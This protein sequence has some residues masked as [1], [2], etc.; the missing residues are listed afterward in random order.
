[1]LALPF[2]KRRAAIIV[3]SFIVWQLPIVLF[4]LSC[5]KIS[6]S[7]A[8]GEPHRPSGVRTIEV[9]STY[10]KKYAARVR[11]RKIRRTDRE[12]NKE[13]LIFLVNIVAC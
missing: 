10:R 12:P 6:G 4:A 5:G 9:R 2:A 13:S 3:K 7:K 11:S 8:T 1:V